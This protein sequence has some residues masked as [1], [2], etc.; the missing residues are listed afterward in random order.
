[1]LDEDEIKELRK[2]IL[3]EATL[4]K[5]GIYVFLSLITLRQQRIKETEIFLMGDPTIP[6]II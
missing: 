2:K 3:E 4:I 1:M 5:D 6:A